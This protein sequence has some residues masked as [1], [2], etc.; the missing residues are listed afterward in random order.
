MVEA[1]ATQEKILSELNK[2]AKFFRD[3]MNHKEVSLE[4][5]NWSIKAARVASDK[6]VISYTTKYAPTT[7]IHE[8]DNGELPMYKSAYCKGLF[9]SLLYLANPA[10]NYTI[11]C[12][13]LLVDIA[14]DDLTLHKLIYELASII[15]ERSISFEE[16]RKLLSNARVKVFPHFDALLNAVRGW[17]FEATYDTSAEY[18]RLLYKA[19][20]YFPKLRRSPS[21]T[22]YRCIAV[23]NP[24]LVKTQ[25]KGK[26]LVLKHR[27]YSSWTYSL[28]AAKRFGSKRI[29]QID[30]SLIPIIIRKKFSD[31]N[32]VCNIEAAGVLLE[33]YS[34]F[35]SILFKEE[36]EIVVRNPQNNFVFKPTD[37]YLYG[38]VGDKHHISWKT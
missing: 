3:F 38:I 33:K 9:S 13:N 20:E 16:F 34:T 6:L 7:L 32:I 21:S 15:L 14:T 31:E 29:S 37:I 27:T 8:A 11:Y 10:F 25:L 18:G 1:A 19:T 28:N 2:V 26:M 5:H 36:K 35:K 22:L 30:P 4:K 24:L 23:S 17:M 12:K